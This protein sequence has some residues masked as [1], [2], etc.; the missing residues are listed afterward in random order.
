MRFMIRQGLLIGAILAAGAFTQA[1]AAEAPRY[2]LTLKPAAPDAQ[3]HVDAL[4]VSIVEGPVDAPAGAAIL[5]MPLVET[6][7]VTDATT[8]QG[9]SVTDADGAVPLTTRDDADAG[10]TFYRHWVTGRAVHGDLAIRYRAPITNALPVR[11]AAPPLDMRTDDGGFGGAGSTFLVLPDSKSP[12]RFSLKWDLSALAK[13]AAAISNFGPGDVAPTAP[14]APERLGSLYVMAGTIGLYPDPAPKQGFMSAWEGHPPFDAAALMAWTKT[15]HDAYDGL[16]HADS[17][18]PYAV[19]LRRNLVNAGGGVEL[20]GAFI[21]SWGAKTDSDGFKVTLAHEMLHT[22]VGGLDTPQGLEGSWF[23]EGT[24]VFYAR[25]LALR[26]HHISPERFLE[27]LNS[28]AGRYYS[29]P[30]ADAPNSEIPKRFWADTRI[31]VLPYDRGS[32]YF[33]VV[34][35]E[36]RKAS[37][38]KR[39]LDDLLLS[40]LARRHAGKPMDQAAWV[41]TVT[42][43]LGPRGKTELEAMLSGALQ[44]PPSDAFG[45]CFRR[46]TKPLR[47]Y[48]LGFDPKVLVEPKRIV[49]GLV[50]GSEAAKAGLHDGDEILKPVPQD[51]IQ[52]DQKATLTLDIRRDG[53]DLAIT[54]LPRGETVPAYQWERVRGV[55][56]KT[57]AL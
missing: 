34:D 2:Q 54:Y 16:F 8:L 4:D 35:S 51:A 15:L 7:V 42:R 43:A 57:C 49:R 48:E 21:G 36:V 32:M 50:A 39:N 37:R 5:R 44:L 52:A 30:L 29:N 6:N 25:R 1:V 12:V 14:I 47:R 27:D 13:G 38:G 56:D 31:R 33:S 3:G 9:F 28:T 20:D 26:F 17:A 41:E 23:T 55:P 22:Y 40:M 19:F 10:Q 18:R 24:A 45:P 11:G 53:R 46:T